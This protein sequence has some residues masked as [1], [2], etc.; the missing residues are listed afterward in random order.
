MSVPLGR[1]GADVWAVVRVRTGREVGINVVCQ[2]LQQ[3]VSSTPQ[4]GRPSAGRVRRASP[5]AP[6]FTHCLPSLH[7][8]HLS[9]PRHALNLQFAAQ[10]PPPGAASTD[11][12]LGGFTVASFQPTSGLLPSPDSLK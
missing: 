6:P 11:Y 7:P 9:L 2:Q 5:P 12:L 4:C 8:N 10:S 1:G 3:A